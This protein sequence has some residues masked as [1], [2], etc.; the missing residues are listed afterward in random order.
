[1][2]TS[3]ANF[4]SDYTVVHIPDGNFLAH[5]EQLYVNIDLIRFGCGGRSA[6]TLQPPRYVNINY[7]LAAIYS[8]HLRSD[9]SKDKFLTLFQF[10]EALQEEGQF[11]ATVLALVKIIQCALSLFELF[12]IGAKEQNGLLCDL[13][14]EGLKKWAKEIGQPYMKVQTS[15]VS[16]LDSISPVRFM[17]VFLTSA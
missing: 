5:R 13:T 10:K 12:P 2:V 15:S 8:A 1:M 11:K 6:L 14:T 17:L 3:L 9:T 7:V 16:P 4:R